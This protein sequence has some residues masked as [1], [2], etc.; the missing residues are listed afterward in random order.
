MAGTADYAKLVVRLEAQSDRLI[1]ELEKSNKKLDRFSKR[2]SQSLAIFKKAAVAAMA[3]FSVSA[4][5]SSIQGAL[6]YADAIQKAADSIGVTTTELQKYRY[7]ANIAGVETSMFDQGL[8]AFG[9][10]LGELRAGTG[11]LS[12]YLNKVDTNFAKVLSGSTSTGEAFEKLIRYAD[13]LGSQMDRAALFA[14]AFSR[15]AGVK[16][17]NLLQQGA[18][19]FDALTKKAQDMGMV[20][21]RDVIDQ[22]AATNDKL[23]T[24]GS[25]LRAKLYTALIKI[26]PYLD[27]AADAIIRI[28]QGLNDLGS[29]SNV[30]RI[31]ELQTKL[32]ALNDELSMWQQYKAKQGKDGFFNR[33]FG[34]TSDNIDSNIR[35]VSQKI[36]DLNKQIEAL[37][38]KD[39]KWQ[40]AMH[41]AP[42]GSTGGKP[43]T[44]T[45]PVK[46]VYTVEGKDANLPGRM[47]SDLKKRADEVR[48]S[49]KS[50]FDQAFDSL[51]QYDALV[52]KG[53][54]S[55]N[56]WGKAT[57]KALDDASS[58]FDKLNTKL[59]ESNGMAA[60]LGFTFSSA[61]ED[62]IVSGGKLSDVMQGL[63]QDIARI[64]VRKSLTEPLGG[65][66]GKWASNLFHFAGGT[67]FAPGGLSIVGEMGPE[68]AY[69]PKGTQIAPNSA[70]NALGGPSNVQ[71]NFSIVANDT[72]GFDTLLMQRRPLIEGIINAAFN[73]QGKRGIK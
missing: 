58:N 41:G 62:A 12:T 57:N 37:Q 70:L 69:L 56:D 10:R 47:L 15:T 60:D 31:Q 49:I 61:F 27:K 33:L 32:G 72:R 20:L 42:E 48:A 21:S 53:A 34:A 8:Q 40:V 46:Q 3:V 5:K 55:V 35:R 14:A 71:V 2:G 65:M 19:G 43:R 54:L 73:K 13:G 64:V 24:M 63:A 7:A 17:T 22:A 51:S 68:L 44:I 67:N 59:D 25:V 18:K 39:K 26:A 38:A 30:S 45:I 36:L 16:M 28:A 23:T 29:L 52:N 6:D 11:A 66:I 4:I 9:K 1:T 50:P